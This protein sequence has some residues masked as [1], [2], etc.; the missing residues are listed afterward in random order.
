MRSLPKPTTASDSGMVIPR[1]SAARNTTAA[2]ASSTTNRP[3][4]GGRVSR[5]L[6]T[7]A[8]ISCHDVGF[9]SGRPLR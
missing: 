1:A 9:Q 6:M 3:V 5:K 2:S 7:S 4:C 8:W